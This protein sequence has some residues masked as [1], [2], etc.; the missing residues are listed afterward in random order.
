MS[1]WTVQ[2]PSPK[3]QSAWESIRLWFIFTILW[4]K[5][6]MLVTYVHNPVQ[7]CFFATERICQNSIPY[8]VVHRPD[9]CVPFLFCCLPMVG[10]MLT[11]IWLLTVLKNLSP[12][13]REVKQVAAVG[14]CF[15]FER[16]LMRNAQ[17]CNGATSAL[18]SF[19]FVFW[20]ILKLLFVFLIFLY[21]DQI[22]EE[23]V[24]ISGSAIDYLPWPNLAKCGRAF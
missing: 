16:W 21:E 19:P 4:L 15:C 2:L 13:L 23:V 1:T 9:V 18:F 8:F 11:T 3:H 17:S 24:K 12:S 6:P 20:S 14:V 10:G 5:I 7:L 22:N